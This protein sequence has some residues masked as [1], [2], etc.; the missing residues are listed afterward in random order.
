MVS[1]RLQYRQDYHCE[2]EN[3]RYLIEKAVKDVVVRIAIII[4]GIYIMSAG[5]VI[6]YQKGGAGQFKPQPFSLAS[7]L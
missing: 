3:Y 6:N 2:Q 5:E 7:V 4:N 1:E